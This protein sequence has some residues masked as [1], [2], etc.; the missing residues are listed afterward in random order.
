MIQSRG[1]RCLVFGVP[2][3]MTLIIQILKALVARA[4]AVTGE[5]V[6]YVVI[7]V[8]VEFGP[9]QREATKAAAR[10]GV[11]SSEFHYFLLFLSHVVTV[12]ERARTA[13]LYCH[14]QFLCL[15]LALKRCFLSGPLRLQAGGPSVRPTAAAATGADRGRCGIRGRQNVRH[16][17]Y[18]CIEVFMYVGFGS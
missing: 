11:T 2:A 7:T 17:E 15:F 16:L 18:L 4:E 6:E 10:C 8:P 14:L 12:I 13:A 3:A 5:N 9:R 1:V